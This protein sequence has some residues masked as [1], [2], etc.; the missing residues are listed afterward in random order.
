MVRCLCSDCLITLRA[1]GAVP[2]A[3]GTPAPGTAQCQPGTD[4]IP[5]DSRTGWGR[6]GAE[7]H[8]AHIPFTAPGDRAPAESCGYLRCPGSEVTQVH[9]VAC[10]AT[11]LQSILG[12]S[13]S[14]PGVQHTALTVPELASSCYPSPQAE[15]PSSGGIPGAGDGTPGW[16]EQGWML[17]QLSTGAAKLLCGLA[18]QKPREGSQQHQQSLGSPGGFGAC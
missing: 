16:G 11:G 15:Q 5:R 18:L 8:R 2:P 9:P 3:T 13:F 14:T 4:R 6:S 7:H 17:A 12:G 10:G 1:G